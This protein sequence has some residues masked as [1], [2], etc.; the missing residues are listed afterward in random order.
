MEQ[1]IKNVLDRNQNLIIKG[2]VLVGGFFAA[3]YF[4]EQLAKN[5]SSDNAFD[6]ENIML[7]NMLY[8][9][10]HIWGG[11]AEDEEKLIELAGY[12]KD[13]SKVSQAYRA[14]YGVNL[15]TE[16]AKWLSVDELQQFKAR[17]GTTVTPAGGSDGTTPTG[18]GTPT[19]P[20]GG[21]TNSLRIGQKVYFKASNWNVRSNASPYRPIRLTKAGQLAGFVAQQPK[22]L[23]AQNTDGNI[24]RDNFVLLSDGSLFS[25]NYYVSISCLRA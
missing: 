23:Y 4:L 13:Y 7:A 18:G 22:V 20:T 24:V 8:Q 16:L 15:D 21:N 1:S 19:T 5:A 14:K 10:G 6:D 3:K 11:I 12:I 25:S 17:L 2:V 9:A